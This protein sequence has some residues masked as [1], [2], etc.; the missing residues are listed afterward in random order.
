MQEDAKKSKDH[1]TQVM[2]TFMSGAF[3]AVE[4]K[5]FIM[6]KGQSANLSVATKAKLNAVVTTLDTSTDA[7]ISGGTFF[8]PS[9]SGKTS[10]SSGVLVAQVDVDTHNTFANVGHLESGALAVG[11]VGHD[12]KDG[13]V[14]VQPDLSLAA[15][16]PK[17]SGP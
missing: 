9:F 5:Q 8:G 10:V 17:P 6:E 15:A 16:A 14:L 1:Q 11:L 7:S 2:C 12:E 3:N 4:P 13:L